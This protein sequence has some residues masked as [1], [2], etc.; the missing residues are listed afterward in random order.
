LAV[1]RLPVG[2]RGGVSIVQCVIR[3]VHHAIEFGVDFDRVRDVGD[4]SALHGSLVI[5][6]ARTIEYFCVAAINEIPAV[7]VGK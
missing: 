7:D 5:L 1:G 4:V 6:R 2:M 3:R